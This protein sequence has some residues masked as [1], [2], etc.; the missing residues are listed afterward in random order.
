M[1]A[2]K[3]LAGLSGPN[4]EWEWT[5]HDADWIF[6]GKNVFDDANLCIVAFNVN[7]CVLLLCSLFS[8]ELRSCFFKS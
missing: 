4:G 3:G 5:P 8:H 6:P 2:M 1:L 7:N